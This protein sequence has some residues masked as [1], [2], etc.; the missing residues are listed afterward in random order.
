MTQVSDEFLLAY[1]DGQLEKTQAAEVAE[2]A[3]KNS[4]ISR[5]LLRLKRTQAQILETFGGFAREDVAVPRLALNFD[6]SEAKAKSKGLSAQASSEGRK[7]PGALR[8][9]LFIGAV[10][11][12]G[13]AGGYGATLLPS[14]RASAPNKDA[15]RPAAATTVPSSWANDIAR[16]HSYFPRE[17]LTPYPDAIAN[18]DLIGFQLSKITAKG[19]KA[20]DFSHQSYTL[21]RGQTFNYRQDRMMQLTY[22][23]K[24]EPPLTLYVLPASEHGDSGAAPQSIG[25]NKAVSWVTDRIRFLLAGEKNEEDLKV[26][27]ALAQSQLP[28]RP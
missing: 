2:L 22:T 23:S 13:I 7:A 1:L 27:A 8:Q 19:L 6:E 12:S 18:P 28:K 11:A 16:F 9:M 26:L 4:E 24:S 5:R 25:S 3:D 20:P 14:H 10:F 15:E 17:T 21:Y